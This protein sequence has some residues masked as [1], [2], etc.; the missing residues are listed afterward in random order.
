MQRNEWK[1]KGTKISIVMCVYTRNQERTLKRYTV[2]L[3]KI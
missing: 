1:N 2:D 3:K